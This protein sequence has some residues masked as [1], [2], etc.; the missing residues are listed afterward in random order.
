[1]EEASS[2][3][4]KK[5]VNKRKK[6]KK[7]EDEFLGF[8]EYLKTQG[9]LL[10]DIAMDG[11]CMF[12]SIAHQLDNNVEEHFK[13]REM[14]VEHIAK[15]K[16]HFELF[17]EGEDEGKYQAYIYSMSKVG[18]WGGD[19]ELAALSEA[20][21]VQFYIIKETHEIINI[22]NPEADTVYLAY[23]QRKS[24]YMSIVKIHEQHKPLLKSSQEI[25]PAKS[26]KLE[27]TKNNSKEN[28]CQHELKTKNNN[29]ENRK[30]EIEKDK[31][32][33]FSSIFS[34]DEKELILWC[35][36][37]GIIQKASRC[38]TCRSKTGKTFGL[39]LSGYKNCFDKYVWRCQKRDCGYMAF[40]RTGNKLL[41]AFSRIKLRILLI[42]VFSHFAFLIPSTVT[43]KTFRLGP[44]VIK[45]LYDLLSTWIIEFQKVDE[46]LKG[47]FGGPNSI[48]EFDES[49]FFKRKNNTGR[50][51]K[52]I[53]GFGFVEREWKIFC[54]GS[55]KQNFKDFNPNYSSMD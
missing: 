7:Q 15:N 1:M 37:V 21:N 53:W 9:F 22:G 10:I 13:Y 51:L 42:I 23:S 5:K 36:N 20:L 12:R 32:T 50:I 43:M 49:C 16:E 2:I 28:N 29:S 19:I 44:K 38:P 4:R 46:I 55:C 48:V 35:V 52:N 30:I 33:D 6:E 34:L 18:V 31:G 45:R 40:I 17:M 26:Q 41:E 24:H 11:N 54:S 39:R 27:E 8:R 47:K 25:I 3:P 14:A